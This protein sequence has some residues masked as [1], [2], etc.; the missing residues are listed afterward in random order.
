VYETVVIPEQTLTE[1]SVESPGEGWVKGESRFVETKPGVPAVPETPEESYWEY[2]YSKTVVVKEAVYA[3]EYQF[4]HVNNANNVKWST[5]PN[6]NSESNNQSQGFVRTGVTREGELLEEAVVDTVYEWFDEAP[7]DGW[8]ATGKSRKVVTQEYVPGDP[9]VP[10]EGYD[11][12]L[13]S[14]TIPAT[15][16]QKQVTP[17]K[18]AW[19]EQKLVSPAV[20]AGPPC[21]QEPGTPPVTPPVTPEEPT[22]DAPAG[23]GIA[24]E[25]GEVPESEGRPE[26]AQPDDVLAAES[27]P[28]SV[29]A[30]LG[31]PIAPV[32][33]SA[34]LLG[35]G[36]V[37]A[38]LLMLLIAGSAQVGRRRGGHA[39]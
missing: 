4:V 29:A 34:G 25:E 30:G 36:L 38:G 26:A 6:W 17:A 33:S 31:G 2:E 32:G 5:D 24:G 7:G 3:I 16:G 14:L 9:A 19:T 28:T 23:D 15:T 39:I 12:Y 21:P 11:E 20:P 8:Q 18:A 22:T 37:A 13:W 35:Q 1:W 27:V 10:A